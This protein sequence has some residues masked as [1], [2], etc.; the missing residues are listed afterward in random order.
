M[1]KLLS[2]SMN[3][4]GPMKKSDLVADIQR[5]SDVLFL[6]ETL[7]MPHDLNLFDKID[8][9]ISPHAQSSV[10]FQEI[11]IGRSHVE[12]TI[13]WH[14]SISHIC[15][16]ITFDDKHVIGLRVNCPHNPLLGN[17]IYLPYY[18]EDNYNDYLFYSSKLLPTIEEGENCGIIALKDFNCDVN[19]V[20]HQELIR[21][22]VEH[23]VTFSDVEMLPALTYTHISICSLCKS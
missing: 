5:K 2:V 19:S 1:D 7:A 6:Q 21:V 11:F 18:S 17:K 22:S 16:V 15:Q 3:F 8:D 4:N 20:F 12:L 14:N 13:L 23:S 9:N 10:D